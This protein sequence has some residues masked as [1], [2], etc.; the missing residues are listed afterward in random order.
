MPYQN[1]IAAAYQYTDKDALWW[2]AL[3]ITH[4]TTGPFY[5]TN[6]PEEFTAIFDGASQL[7]VPIPF[8]VKQP[9]RDG[10]GQQDLSIAICNVGNEMLNALRA[11]AAAGREPIRVY[12]TIYLN[13]NSAPQYDPPLELML[14][15]VTLTISQ[16][17][18][19]ATRYNVFD[20]AFPYALFRPDTYPGLARR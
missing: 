5:I 3:V 4:P 18:G 9:D 1:G 8:E 2:E 20:R 7:F 15:N 13:G 12:W 6:A 14:T 17:T 19:V 10:E 11:A 16:M